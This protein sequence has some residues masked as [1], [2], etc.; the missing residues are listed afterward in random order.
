[1]LETAASH[2]PRGTVF[3]SD[4]PARLERLPWSAWHWRI[5]IVFGVTW[6]LDGLEVTLVGSVSSVL[7]EPGTLRLTETQIGAAA[8]AYL[9]GAILGALVFGKLTD[10]LG[11]KRLFLVTLA[12]Y[13]GA[14][15]LNALSLGHS[16]RFAL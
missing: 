5:V 4:L 6:V 7:A 1:V 13:L 8:S 9:A 12:V 2:L 3:R 11:R 16:P 10:R 15:V 14:T